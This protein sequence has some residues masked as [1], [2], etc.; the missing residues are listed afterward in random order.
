MAAQPQRACTFFLQNRCRKGADCQYA[1]GT[2]K[3]VVEQDW[4]GPKTGKPSIPITTSPRKQTVSEQNNTA[5]EGL[6]IPCKYFQKGFCSFGTSCFY[7]HVIPSQAPL[8]T[9]TPKTVHSNA[10]KVTPDAATEKTGDNPKT[11][12]GAGNTQVRVMGATLSV[13]FGQGLKISSVGSASATSIITIHNLPADTS[14]ETVKAILAEFEQDLPP[15]S[16]RVIP[17]EES[18]Y[19]TAKLNDAATAEKIIARLDG[20]L[21]DD[22]RLSVKPYQPKGLSNVS[23]SATRVSCTWFAPSK[24]ASITFRDHSA[25]RGAVT[26]GQGKRIRGRKIECKLQSESYSGRRSR[27]RG[28][29]S[30]GNLAVNTTEQDLRRIM[31]TGFKSVFFQRPTYNSS[32]DEAM[33]Y[34]I[35]LLEQ[36]KSEIEGYE[37]VSK[38]EDNKTK[39]IIRFKSEA[40]AAISVQNYNGK[41]QDFLGNSPIFLQPIYTANFKIAPEIRRAVAKELAELETEHKEIARI[42]VF[43]GSGINSSHALA[44]VR[45]T[46]PKKSDVASVKALVGNLVRG[47]LCRREAGGTGGEALWDPYFASVAGIRRITQIGHDTKTY[48]Y[49]DRRKSQLFLF[50]AEDK[51]REAAR[52]LLESLASIEENS[53]SLPI[54]GNLWRYFMRE[55]LRVLQ[56]KFGQEKVGINVVKRCITFNGTPAELEDARMMLRNTEAKT[57]L[58]SGEISGECPIC[59]DV[60][61]N[62]TRFSSCDHVYCSS[63]LT[64]YIKSTLDT[65]K[66]PIACVGETK[67]LPCNCNLELSIASSALSAA[68]LESILATSFSDYIRRRPSEYAY[69]PTP[70]CNT[71]YSITSDG[72][73]FSCVDCLLDICTSCKVEAH[74]GMTCIN[75][76]C[77]KHN[78]EKAQKEYE[79]WKKQNGV[80]SCP[81][82]STDIQKASGCN[83][84]TCGN[85][86]AHI[87]WKCLE[88]F[89]SSEPVY[90]H[91][92]RTH[93]DIGIEFD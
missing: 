87:C 36:Q 56:D 79:E 46:G 9:E 30:V 1:H 88:V 54:P 50:G 62:P 12:L 53:H 91:M 68:E 13:T 10:E 16:L 22:H 69:C 11:P 17:L 24:I 49:C 75:Y 82:C 61:E 64:D 70:N 93:G 15:D 73:V 57:T 66:F 67:G 2:P 71:V 80:Q 58:P 41:K 51:R 72:K 44:T 27:D 63:C 65:R 21:H 4:R 40:A 48:I 3:R 77:T 23:Q 85:C 52:L 33:V 90:D 8:A 45:I 6:F 37:I 86:K 32:P 31:R 78:D 7:A 47:Q 83:H 89:E 84:I 76:R 34:I 43:G 81:K 39:A 19:A 20:M 5:S 26:A 59:F 74:D 42:R 28:E 29:I 25:A 55:G 60:A 14:A 18:T 35:S 38:P 92:N